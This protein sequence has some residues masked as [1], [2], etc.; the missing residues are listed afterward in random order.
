MRIQWLLGGVAALLLAGCSS[1]SN[2]LSGAG[3]QVRVVE[4]QPGAECQLLGNAEGRQSNW[5]SGINSD[6]ESFKSAVNDLRNKAALAGGNVVYGV[7]SEKQNILSDL[8]P[9]DTKVVGQVYKCPN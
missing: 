6:Y 9:M 1:S 7:V 5:M 8:A 4:E 2:T 3:Q